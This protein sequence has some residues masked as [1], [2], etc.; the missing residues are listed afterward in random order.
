MCIELLIQKALD[1]PIREVRL[2]P[3]LAMY[4]TNESLD[5]AQRIDR[6]ENAKWLYGIVE[7]GVFYADVLTDGGFGGNGGVSIEDVPAY[8]AVLL[9]TLLDDSSYRTVLCHTHPAVTATRLRA[10]LGEDA[11]LLITQAT[12]D[13]E[14]GLFSYLGPAA[15]IDDVLTEIYSRQLSD[16]DLRNTPGRYHLLITPTAPRHLNWYD[17]STGDL[18]KVV[19]DMTSPIFSRIEKRHQK[20]KRAWLKEVFGATDVFR[21]SPERGLRAYLIG[22]RLIEWHPDLP[23]DIDTSWYD[24]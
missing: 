18:V 17:L 3:D 13:L 12:Q 4:A 24:V 14:E 6:S 9:H 16:D 5:V 1:V 11:E 22:H 23:L 10:S 15:T 7:D 2:S 20:K 21:L 8:E 19:E